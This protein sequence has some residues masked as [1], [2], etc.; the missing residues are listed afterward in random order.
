MFLFI[1]DADFVDAGIP[2]K[3]LFDSFPSVLLVVVHLNTSFLPTLNE[4][5]PPNS[6]PHSV[7]LFRCQ[8]T[9]NTRSL[10]LEKCVTREKHFSI[11][12]SAWGAVF[13]RIHYFCRATL[14][15]IAA[16]Q[17]RYRGAHRFD[18]RCVCILFPCAVA[19]SI[20][21]EMFFNRDVFNF[22]DRCVTGFRPKACVFGS[23]PVRDFPP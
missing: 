19:S 2:S 7:D 18:S 1:P 15:G 6:K 17:F 10:L 20:W 8:R 5:T 21:R 4:R 14:F 3:S 12:R 9:T 23:A 13:G 11:R 22:P 16:T